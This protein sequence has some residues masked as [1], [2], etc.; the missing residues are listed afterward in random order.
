MQSTKRNMVLHFTLKLISSLC[1]ASKVSKWSLSL[2]V[3]EKV[4]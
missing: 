3:E 4:T 1:Q 2:S